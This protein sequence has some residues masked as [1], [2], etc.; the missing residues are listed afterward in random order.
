MSCAFDSS[1]NKVVIT[2]RD[3]GNSNYGTA[4]VGTVDSSD[5]SI[6]FGTKAVVYSASSSYN[7]VRLT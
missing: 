3:A 1:N 6:S 5:N 4:I 7:L 2:Y